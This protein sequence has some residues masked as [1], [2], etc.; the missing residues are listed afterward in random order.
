MDVG[1]VGEHHLMLPAQ[2]VQRRGMAHEGF[3]P[4]GLAVQ[5][6]SGPRASLLSRFRAHPKAHMHLMLGLLVIFAE[7]LL[8]LIA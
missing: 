5:G 2:L 6:H 4:T 7:A 3:L 8:N 1:D